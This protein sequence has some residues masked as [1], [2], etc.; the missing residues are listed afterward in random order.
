M[1]R[2]AIVTGEYPPQPGGV[3]DYTRQVARALTAAGDSVTV[4]TSALEASQV[5]PADE[6]FV[7]DGVA[8]VRLS[9]HFGLRGLGE[10]Q[11]RLRELRPDRIW[12]QYVPHAYGH[13]AMNVPFAWWA[14]WRAVKIAPVW[15]MFHE[16]MYPI[17]PGQ[18]LRLGLLS[19]IHRFMARRLIAAG[20]RTFVSIPTWTNLLT[21]IAP[22]S[23]KLKDVPPEWLPVPSNIPAPADPRR[24]AAIGCSLFT[25]PQPTVGHFGTFGPLERGH[26]LA[27]LAQFAMRKT[28]ISLILVGRNA[29]QFRRALLAESSWSENQV[30]AAEN[31]PPEEVAALLSVC[32]VLLQPYPDGVSCRRTTVMAGLALG[33]P[34]VTNLGE[35]SE[36]IWS[37]GSHGVRLVRSN[38]PDA[39]IAATIDEL[40]LPA[41]QRATR[42]AANAAWYQAEFA[43]ERIIAKLKRTTPSAAAG[44]TSAS[45][46]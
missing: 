46:P 29:A 28:R 25:D 35:L 6:S 38:D 15:V 30:V 36:P 39:L 44:A 24:V 31:L 34:I 23:E 45:R 8:V 42:G 5:T 3:A 2:W 21:T 10:L 12:L 27:T 22:H 9:D 19:R 18:G 37:K 20:S 11:R 17:V 16:V 1:T 14:A 41:E 7:N 40:Q 13:K 43:V 26:L 32:D 4:F 33:L